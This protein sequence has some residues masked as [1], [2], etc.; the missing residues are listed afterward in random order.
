MA[1]L[2]AEHWLL[3]LFGQSGQIKMSCSFLREGRTQESEPGGTGGCWPDRFG[4]SAPKAL[5]RGENETKTLSRNP[6]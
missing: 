2:G 3:S 1:C 5:A 4:D 6:S